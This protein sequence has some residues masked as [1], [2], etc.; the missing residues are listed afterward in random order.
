MR[1]IYKEWLPCAIVCLSYTQAWEL[2]VYVFLMIW[3]CLVECICQS[4]ISTYKFKYY[5]VGLQFA[6]VNVNIKFLF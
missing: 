2:H 4:Q 1:G 5:M 3:M 6:L